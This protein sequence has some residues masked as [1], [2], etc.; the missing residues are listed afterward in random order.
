M[1]TLKSCEATP[2]SQ[3]S[4]KM[5]KHT[6]ALCNTFASE[7]VVALLEH[8][9]SNHPESLIQHPQCTICK[10]SDYPLVTGKYAKFYN[11]YIL[12]E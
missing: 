9:K 11:K 8:T 12:C 5:V 6:C 3:I 10:Q 1:P 7:S 4:P 2:K